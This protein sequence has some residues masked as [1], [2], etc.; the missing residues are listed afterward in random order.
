MNDMQTRFLHWVISMSMYLGATVAAI[1]SQAN[2]AFLILIVGLLLW[3]T[4]LGLGEM[5]NDRRISSMQ[6]LIWGIG[7]GTLAIL[8]LKDG[9]QM[10]SPTKIS[11]IG[12]ALG[13]GVFALTLILA[14]L[15]WQSD[16]QNEQNNQ[17]TKETH[18]LKREL[19]TLK[20]ELEKLKTLIHS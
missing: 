9:S 12:I 18:L 11:T 5:E 10:L 2:L 14:I 20:R 4:V 3:F 15:L 13:G 6:V 19:E 7:F 16:S 8:F 1:F 17:L